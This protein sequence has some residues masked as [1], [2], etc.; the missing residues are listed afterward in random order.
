MLVY[1]MQKYSIRVLCAR[2]FQNKIEESVYSLLKDKAL[3]LGVY[4][5][6]RFLKSSIECKTTNSKAVFYGLNRNIDE[7]KSLENISICWVEEANFIT[8]TQFNILTPTIRATNSE[9]WLSFNPKEKTDYIYKRFVLKDSD[10]TIVRKIN[11]PDNPYAPITLIEEAE[12]MKKLDIALYKHI[13]LGNCL[14]DSTNKFFKNL[15]SLSRRVKEYKRIY[16]GFDVADD[17]SDPHAI[18][19]ETDNTIIDILEIYGNY[20]KGINTLINILNKLIPMRKEII[21][22]YDAIGV[23]AGV[24]HSLKDFKQIKIIPFKASNAVIKQNKKEILPYPNKE[25]YYNLKAQIWHIMG[26][27]TSEIKHQEVKLIDKLIEQLETPLITY[28]SNKILVEK[29]KEDLLKRGVPS[30]NLADSFICILYA[31]YLD[32][33]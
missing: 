20:E 8:E 15:V 28:S 5:K 2:A 12:N 24:G 11:Y 19:I 23:G 16:I 25:A 6:F 14:D 10:N 21:L 26:Y 22:I 27:H 17:G 9:V 33:Y 3:Q 30:P 7:I 4:K 32:M 13:Y 18:T 31:K 29:K 1:L